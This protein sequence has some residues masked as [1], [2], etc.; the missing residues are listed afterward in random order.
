M[1]FDEKNVVETQ[2]TD[3]RFWQVRLAQDGASKQ[4]LPVACSINL[5]PGLDF[6][7]Y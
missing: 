2:T 5:Y 6:S 1:V 4:N 7:F 3:D